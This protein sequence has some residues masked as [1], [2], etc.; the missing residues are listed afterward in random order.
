MSRFT[1]NVE[2]QLT[3]HLQKELQRDQVLLDA[4]KGHLPELESLLFEFRSDYE[5]RTYRFY[6]QSFKVYSLQDSTMKAVELFRGIGAMIKGKLCDSFEKIVADGTGWEFDI[7]HNKNWLLH[8][9]PIVEAFFHAK[10]FLDMM[11][12][13]GNEMDAVQPIL[14][15]GWA[16]ILCLYNLR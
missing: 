4:I 13:Y 2:K 11:V 14:P 3:D 16:A 15:T 1:S 12:K 8:T 6:Y 5:D 9:R 7:E 10:Y